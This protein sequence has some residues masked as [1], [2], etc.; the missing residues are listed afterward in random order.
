MNDIKM[1]N[2]Q[3]YVNKKLA[4]KANENMITYHNNE[5]MITYHNNEEMI[6]YHNNEE[7]CTH[8]IR[9]STF[10]RKTDFF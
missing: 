4:Q 6:T 9:K 10:L 5:E 3:K 7:M 1:V 8:N 2:K